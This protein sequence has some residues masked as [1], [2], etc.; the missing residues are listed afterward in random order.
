MGMHYHYLGMHWVPR[1]L[2]ILFSGQKRKGL[3]VKWPKYPSSLYLNGTQCAAGGGA[4]PVYSGGY[5][6]YSGGPGTQYSV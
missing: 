6:V 5:P 2:G 4:H 1:I 3:K